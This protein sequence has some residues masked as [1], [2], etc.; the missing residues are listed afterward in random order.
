[1][2]THQ[3]LLNVVC[4]ELGLSGFKVKHPLKQFMDIIDAFKE[5]QV[6]LTETEWHNQIVFNEIEINRCKDAE[7]FVALYKKINQLQMQGKKEED[8]MQ[9]AVY[10]RVREMLESNK[11]IVTILANKI[12]QHKKMYNPHVGKRLD[13]TLISLKINDLFDNSK[14]LELKQEVINVSSPKQTMKM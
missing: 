5:I 3:V 10:P 14:C 11:D 12:E 8:I 13:E 2:N 4:E 6:N 7:L 9:L 1:M